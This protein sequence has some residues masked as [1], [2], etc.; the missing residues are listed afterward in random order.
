ML[1]IKIHNYLVKTKRTRSGGYSFSHATGT[2]DDLGYALTCWSARNAPTIIM[3]QLDDPANGI[4][5]QEK[6]GKPVE[7][8]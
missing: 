2:H 7:R 3:M 8:W 6:L 1:P 5:W 4:T